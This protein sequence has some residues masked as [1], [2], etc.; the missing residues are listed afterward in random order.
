MFLAE[1]SRRYEDWH[2]EH[3]LLTGMAAYAASL[4]DIR[5]FKLHVTPDNAISTYSYVARS[6]NLEMLNHLIQDYGLMFELIKLSN[7][8]MI[9]RAVQMA[10]ESWKHQPHCIILS[11]IRGDSS[12][13]TYVVDRSESLKDLCVFY[14]AIEH[15]L[16]YLVPRIQLS[17][18]SPPDSFN[19]LYLSAAASLEMLKLIETIL[20]PNIQVCSSTLCVGL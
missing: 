4:N 13:T 6:G 20:P 7:L 12:I 16:L 11:F 3:L 19:T 9:K 17:E 10:D 2:V 1:R 14:A 8:N 5:T 18:A 15:N